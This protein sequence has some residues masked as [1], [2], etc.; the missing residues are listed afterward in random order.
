MTEKMTTKETK[1][2]LTYEE[3]VSSIP[4]GRYRHFKGKEYEVIAIARHSET[5]EA[6]VVYKA[7]Y[8]DGGVWCRPASMWLESVE[9]DGK[10][11]KRFERIEESRQ[12]QGE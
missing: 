6:M 12:F 9:R 4:L 5:E 2:L 10:I 3:A 11:Y 7:L 1:I 8:G